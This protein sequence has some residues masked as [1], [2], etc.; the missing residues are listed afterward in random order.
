MYGRIV[1]I[2][3]NGIY[4]YILE[5]ELI[6]KRHVNHI[7]PALVLDINDPCV[8]RNDILHSQSSLH[9]VLKP[10]LRLALIIH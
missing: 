5:Y 9:D 8:N 6:W 4:E 3:G 2:I 10:K 7:T 1:K